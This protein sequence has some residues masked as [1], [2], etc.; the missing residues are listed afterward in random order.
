MITKTFHI[1]CLLLLAAAKI[2]A[3]SIDSDSISFQ[4][5]DLYGRKQLMSN[6]EVR[7]DSVLL[8]DITGGCRLLTEKYRRAGYYRAECVAEYGTDSSSVLV[9]IT[10]G[11]R[12][13]VG[14]IAFEGNVYLSDNYLQDLISTKL[15]E[16]MDS[17]SVVGDMEAISLAYA[18]QGFPQAE[19]SVKELKIVGH[20]LSITFG[21]TEN[22]RVLISRIIF[23]GNAATRDQTLQKI[24]GLKAGS[25]FSR[26]ELEKALEQLKGSGLFTEVSPP[27][28]LAGQDP[29]RQQVLVKVKEAKFNRIFGA[30]S[31]LQPSAE[32][33]GWL[34]GALD[35]YLGNIAGTARNVSV[36]WERPQKENSRLEI[37]YT[38]PF[39]L[40]F[41]VSVS[42]GLKHMIEDSS[43]VKTS[44]G[45]LVKMPLGE[46]FKAGIGA[47][48][49]RIVPGPAMIYQRCNKYS[50]KWL[51]EWRKK[52]ESESMLNVMLKMEADFGRKNYYL[53]TQQLTISKVICDLVAGKDIFTRQELYLAVKG[54]AVITGEKPVPRYDQFSMGGATTLRGYYQE[55]F[56]ANQ[57]VWTNLEYRYKPVNNFMVF[58]FADLGYFFDRERSLR[59]YRAGYGFGFKLDT[60]I[61]WINIVY[62]LGRDDTILNGKVHFGL[63]SE[64]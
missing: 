64:F 17:A 42:A 39:L 29:S 8:K 59:G 9:R 18:D 12:Y 45:L 10:E 40:G 47:E 33:S 60:R 22:A 32:Q 31:Y 30:A 23:Q 49:E 24:S 16:V 36:S 14:E 34:A 35:L 20:S 5:D 41:D 54:R 61:G 44:A 3:R 26:A 55:Q 51:L 28:L 58:P 62:G 63:E 48:Y 2:C 19:V 53:P 11:P 25:A 43:Y 21:I 7:G 50:T 52:G 15:N 46:G 13:L 4:G 56:I 38:E 6:W 27:L 1:A 57:V 37:D